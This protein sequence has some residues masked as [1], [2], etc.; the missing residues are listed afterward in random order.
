[1]KLVIL[2]AGLSGHMAYG[3]FRGLSPVVFDRKEESRSFLSEHKAVM[4][5]K[6]PYAGMLLG[7]Q[8]EQ[9]TVHKQVMMDGNLTDECSI[10]AN[11]LYSRKVSDGLS[12]RSLGELGRV[13][14]YVI[15][16]EEM[17][18]NRFNYGFSLIAV[19][20]GKLYFS[21]ANSENPDCVVEYDM[22]IST[23]PII[24]LAKLVKPMVFKDN[25]ESEFGYV[26]IYTVSG[27]LGFSSSLHQTIY[28]P[29]RDHSAYRAT[30]EGK[31]IIIESLSELGSDELESILGN[32]GLFLPDVE[33]LKRHRQELG[34]LY[35]TRDDDRKNMIMCLTREFDIYSIGRYAIWKQVRSDDLVLDLRHVSKLMRLTAIGREYA[36]YLG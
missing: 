24:Y 31:H 25:S 22:C 34:K 32:F 28:Y 1:V 2:G 18:N 7:V 15:C 17:P 16:S 19:T 5:F 35:S 6:E 36:S 3:F 8:I 9:V 26:P 13:K 4:R 23:I 29:D 20:K 11:N 27:E 33:N 14:R 21:T 12:A 30:L 10:R